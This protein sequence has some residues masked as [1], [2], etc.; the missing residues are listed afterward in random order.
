[1][2]HDPEHIEERI[3][4][5]RA[6][7]SQNLGELGDR[8]SPGNLMDEALR[9][10]DTGPKEFAGSLGN[11]V[12]ENPMGALLTAAGV[13][14]MAMGRGQDPV[15]RYTDPAARD[16]RDPY[17]AAGYDDDDDDFDHRTYSRFASDSATAGNGA[18]SRNGS[19]GPAGFN[20]ASPVSVYDLPD[21][22][23][24]RYK[25][26]ID[27]YDTIDQV[28]ARTRRTEGETDNAYYRRL[29]DSYASTLKIERQD[30]EDDDTYRARVRNAVDT[31]SEKAR[32]ARRTLKQSAR[33]ARQRVAEMR[34]D[35]GRRASEMGDRASAFASDMSDEASYRTQMAKRRAADFHEENPLV[36]GAIALAVGALAGSLFPVSD[37]EREALQPVADDLIE[38]GAALA[39]QGAETLERHAETV[40]QRV[41]EFRDVP[42]DEAA[43]R[44]AG[45]SA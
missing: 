36:S 15:R 45:Q 33:R 24:T 10:F 5:T 7:L 19:E 8:M 22:E 43:R 6:R 21:D 39:E 16:Y 13:A 9:Y 23:V 3:E 17:A 34:R 38:R 25:S 12:R 37:K 18:W 30:G 26:S 27:T 40:E 42:L 14:W 4:D 31:A 2:S 20:G 44:V 41:G 28:R 32:E 35:A 29:D 11:Q 1:M